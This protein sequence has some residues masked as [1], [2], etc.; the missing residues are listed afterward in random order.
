MHRARVGGALG[1]GAHLVGEARDLLGEVGAHLLGLVGGA[2]VGGEL[3]REL[4]RTVADRRAQLMGG[5]GV[6]VARARASV[7][8]FPQAAADALG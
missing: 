1:L 3:L 5:A 6:G 4:A 7:L 8:E 2:L